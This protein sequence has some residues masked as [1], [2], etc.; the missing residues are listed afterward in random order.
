METHGESTKEATDD[1]DMTNLFLLFLPSFSLLLAILP[2]S[3][4]LWPICFFV[5]F[6]FCSL[7]RM[8]FLF[9]SPSVSPSF[10]SVV[11]TS[12]PLF[13]LSFSSFSSEI[14]VCAGKCRLLITFHRV[15]LSDT[16]QIKKAGKQQACAKFRFQLFFLLEKIFFS[17]NN[18]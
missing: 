15:A 2:F 10:P 9:A 8:Y 14:N 16:S 18:C 11:V 3:L 4:Y 13:T 7:C 6:F 5:V 1:I 17:S 12:H